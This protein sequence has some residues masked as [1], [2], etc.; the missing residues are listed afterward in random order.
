MKTKA[1]I[2]EAS[3]NLGNEL[4]ELN[5]AILA[6]IK[7]KK[8]DTAKHSLL[9]TYSTAL[10]PVLKH[11]EH[12][13][14]AR[15]ILQGADITSSAVLAGMENANPATL[16]I[17]RLATDKAAAHTYRMFKKV[18]ESNDLQPLRV[19]VGLDAN[20]DAKPRAKPV[21]AFDKLINDIKANTLDTDKLTQLK[22]AL[23]VYEAV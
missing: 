23:G 2:F 20:P 17:Y 5:A 9:L 15:L 8:A 12:Y 10:L 21:S 19:F 1:Q 22:S 13:A 7:A 14:T 16:I 3:R 4:V 11:P 18:I 6:T